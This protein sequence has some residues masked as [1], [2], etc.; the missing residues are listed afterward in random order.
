MLAGAATLAGVSGVA[1]LSSESASADVS[2][3]FQATGADATVSGVPSAIRID[4]SG[5]WSVESAG[6]IEQVRITLQARVDGEIDDLATDVIF[7]ATSGE[8]AV[9]ADVLADHRDVDASAFMPDTPGETEATDV[10]IRV[11]VSAVRDGGVVAEASVEDTAT[12]TVTEAGVAVTTGGQASV[13]V[14]A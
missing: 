10:V 11:V 3:D 5:A 8:Y 6:P 2:G 12:V 14:E 7:D 9:S 13:S 4:A 1:T